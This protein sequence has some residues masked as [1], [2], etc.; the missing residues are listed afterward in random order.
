MINYNI[1]SQTRACTYVNVISKYFFIGININICT[2]THTPT[3]P[4][5]APIHT[6]AFTHTHVHAYVRF[7]HI[8]ALIL[9]LKGSFSDFHYV[10]IINHRYFKIIIYYS[11]YC[12]SH[13][14]VR[15][16]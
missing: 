2:H 11:Y 15:N 3:T 13:Y 9:D 10:H 8:C 7:T 5:H 6:K 14:I 16:I 1:N 12:L 4:K